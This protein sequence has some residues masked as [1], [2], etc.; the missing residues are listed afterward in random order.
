MITIDTKLRVFQYKIL[1]RML[2]KLRKV[3][4]TLCSFSK[5]E[6]KTY[7]RLFYRCRKTSILSRQLQ[8]FFSTG[9]D[10]SSISLHSVFFGFLDDGLEHT[11]L[12]NRILLIFKNI[13]YKARENKSLNFSILKNY[14]TKFRDLE[15]NLKGNDKYS[16]KWTVI[17]SML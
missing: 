16:K 8:E 11:F 14:R 5:A 6:D 4:S 13:L 10:L 1:N 7:I 2:F 12:L 3:E 9:R 15:A 17:N